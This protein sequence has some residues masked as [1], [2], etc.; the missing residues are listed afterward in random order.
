MKK[1]LSHILALA[2]LFSPATALLAAEK[3]EMTSYYPAPSGIYS[4]ILLAPQ[5]AL[6][7][8]N[9]DLGTLYANSGDSSKIYYCGPGQITPLPEFLP[10]AG[11]WTLNVNNLY[12]TDTSTPENKKV[13][14][15]TETAIFKLTL[16]GDGGILSDHLTG[17]FSTLPVSGAG[18]RLMWYPAKGAFRAGYASGTEWDDANIGANSVAMGSGNKAASNAATIW[19]GKNNMANIPLTFDPTVAQVAVI[20]GGESNT[21]NGSFDQILGGANNSAMD[22]S[23]VSGSSNSAKNYSMIGGGALNST[24]IAQYSTILGGYQN[25]T[26]SSYSS[27]SGSGNLIGGAPGYDFD[28]ISGGSANTIP[29]DS[30]NSTISGGQQNSIRDNYSSYSTISGGSGNTISGGTC[31]ISGGKNNSI[32]SSAQSATISGGESNTAA[33]D[34]SSVGGGFTNN[35][36]GLYSTIVGGSSNSISVDRGAII[37]GGGN[38]TTA[39]DYSLVAGRQMNLAATANNSFVWGNSS[40]ALGTPI[41]A[42]NTFL[43]YSGNMGI[44]DITPA[45]KLELNGNGSTED[46][47]AVTSSTTSAPGDI[48]IIKSNGR[49]G[50]GQVNPQYPLEF[51]NGAYV[52]ATGNF[53]N[54]SSRT[55]KENIFDLTLSAAM[56]TFTKLT[57]VQYNYKKEN[58]EQYVGFIAD[59]VPDLVSDQNRKGLAPMD[60]AAVLTTVVSHQQKILNQQKQETE[61]LLKEISELKRRIK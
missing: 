21:T 15:G 59:D 9:C 53:V 10:L 16:V 47:L 39:A 30:A 14:I 5:V 33:R 52:T 17:T 29:G 12:L 48:F 43:I 4:S 32:L 42:P 49:L 58:K 36:T 31:T 61:V 28:T 40:V 26:T 18:T 54:A 35:A 27:L 56:D 37:L 3:L 20:A 51:G 34:Y 24:T 25:S 6:A 11:T 41:A 1:L 57:P 13:A 22:G 60:I 23:R 55:Y 2:F 50:A 44:R 7:S 19:G 46:Y 38:N 45:A 8:S